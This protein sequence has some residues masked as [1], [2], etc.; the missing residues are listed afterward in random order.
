MSSFSPP[1]WRRRKCILVSLGMVCLLSLTGRA[2]ELGRP[3][4]RTVLDTRLLP[5]DLPVL[6]PGVY[7]QTQSL[8]DGGQVR[9]TLSIPAHLSERT[10]IPLV[11]VLHYGGKVTPFYGHHL[12]QELVE[13]A[14][15]ELGAIL[16]APDARE[17]DWTTTK[18]EQA[19]VWLAQSLAKR[20]AIDAR[21][22][23][24]TGYSMGGTGAWYIGNRNQDV[25]RVVIPIASTPA[26]T[27]PWRVPLYVLHATDD[28]LYPISPTRAYAARLKMEGAQLVWSEVN[29]PTH[30]T[31]SAYRDAL[32][33]VVPWLQKS[34][35]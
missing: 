8:P 27:L 33:Q 12:L 9:Y 5:A 2:E 14:L 15:S 29:G 13:P 21:K 25:F 24:L 31:V 17:G 1:H 18:N 3:A 16:V 6:A 32:R 34:W 7:E 19:V 22:L 20:Y 30:F 28:E 23:V 26:G 4:K 11:M 10:A 35:Q